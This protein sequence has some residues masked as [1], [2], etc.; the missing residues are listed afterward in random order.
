MVDAGISEYYCSSTSSYG[1]KILLHSPNEAPMISHYGTSVS[2]GYETRVVITP[3]ISE[4]SDAVRSLPVRVRQC[5]FEAENY[6]TYYRWGSHDI[7]RKFQSMIVCFF[8]LFI[9][10]ILE[11]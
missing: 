10:Y 3:A 4:A 5:L 8:V 1:F 9:G 7:L 2:N 11:A 6:L